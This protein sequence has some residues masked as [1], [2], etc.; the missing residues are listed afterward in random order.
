MRLRIEHRT[1]VSQRRTTVWRTYILC[2]VRTY[3]SMSGS[4]LGT[5]GYRTL[6]TSTS[7]ALYRYLQDY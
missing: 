1:D 6:T 2:T 5:Y 4:A 3:E 7:I